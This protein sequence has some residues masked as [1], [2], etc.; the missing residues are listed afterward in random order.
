MRAFVVIATKGR[1]KETR[2]LLDY[3]QRQTLPLEFAVIVG[4]TPGDLEGMGDHSLIKTGLGEALISPVVGSSAQRNYGMAILEQR[5][6]FAAEKGPFFCAFFDDDYRPA[7]DWLKEA[8]AR[9]LRGD[10]VGLTGRILADGVKTGG[11]T[12]DQAEAFLNGITPPQS[13]WASGAEERGTSS[14]YGCNMAFVDKIIRTTRFD[15]TLA[16]YGWQEDRDYT[17]MALKQGPVVYYPRCAG[18]HLGVKGGRTSGVRLGYSQIANPIYMMKKG[19]MD[20]KNGLHHILR[21]LA[22]N[23]L[24]SFTVQ[25]LVDYR[26][27]FRGN[28]RAIADFLSKRLDPRNILDFKV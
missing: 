12:E 25:P 22:S 8:A 11:L 10:V 19:T 3:L 26:G 28:M 1:A 2:R 27:R 7:D 13:H 23:T 20:Y 18:V 17:G 24:Q 6:F 9:F 16:L 21:A 15:E 14:V 4:T 5:G